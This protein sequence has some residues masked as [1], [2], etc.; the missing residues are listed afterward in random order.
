MGSVSAAC[1][2]KSEITKS[3]KAIIAMPFPKHYQHLAIPSMLK[4]NSE[5]Y[6]SDKSLHTCVTEISRRCLFTD[7]MEGQPCH[8]PSAS[9]PTV[10]RMLRTRD[11]FDGPS[12]PSLVLASCQQ[13]CL[14]AKPVLEHQVFI[15][16]NPANNTILF[17]LTLYPTKLLGL[18]IKSLLSCRPNCAT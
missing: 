17:N 16:D 12:K 9:S 1:S 14:P 5:N 3:H 8:L 4:S 6:S 11:A 2:V 18:N 15:N 13:T 7:S 10:A